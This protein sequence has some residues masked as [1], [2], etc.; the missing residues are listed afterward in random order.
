MS[1]AGIKF[2]GKN[3]KICNKIKNIHVDGDYFIYNEYVCE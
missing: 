1:Q 2:K 3:E